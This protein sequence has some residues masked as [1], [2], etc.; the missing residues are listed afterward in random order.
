VP[1][2]QQQY[3]NRQTVINTIASWGA[4]LVRFRIHADD[5]N[6]LSSTAKTDYIQKVK[7]WRDTVTAKGMW[8]MPC[9][10]NPLDGNHAGAAWVGHASDSDA[11]FTAVYQALGNDPRVIYEPFNEPNNI[12]WTDWQTNMQH[13][14][15][16]FRDTLGYH[17]VLVIDPREY[18]NSGVQ[19]FGY[20][21]TQ[22]TALETFDAARSG[23]SQHNLIW[24]K[25]DYYNNQNAAWSDSAWITGQGGSQITHV[26]LESEFGNFVTSSNDTW[27]QAACAFFKN[28][29]AS[30]TNYAGAA[31][32]LWGPWVDANA[33]SG[34]DNITPTNPW[35][36]RVRD[37]FLA[38]GSWTHTSGTG[39]TSTSYTDSPIGRIGTAGNVTESNSGHGNDSPHGSVSVTG[40]V[41][42]DWGP[43]GVRHDFPTGA[44]LLTGSVSESWTR[45]STFTVAP[46]VVVPE[47]DTPHFAFPFAFQA[48]GSAA[49]VQQDTVEEVAACV[50]NVAICPQGFRTDQPAFGVPDPSFANL[51]IDTQPVEAALTTW[52]PRAAVSITQQDEVVSFAS[53]AIDSAA[54]GWKAGLTVN[55]E[56]A[57]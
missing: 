29:F 16:L 26:V 30:Q 24:A 15:S 51:A 22:Y 25:H 3:N 23:M 5:Y 53:E 35:G 34:T 27:D 41:I 49:V 45:G 47:L 6:A 28:R 2:W 50:A 44:E 54:L 48:D 33:I 19:G 56:I 12:S 21:N 39:A 18:A 31:A 20:D 40:S 7:D 4:N 32:F 9:D 1:F 17:G 11:L 10:W 13:T 55:V 38:G 52:E 36:T 46:A 14:V 42:D 57:P 8:F 43:T 37:L